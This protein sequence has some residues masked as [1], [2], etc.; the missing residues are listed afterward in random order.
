VPDLWTYYE[1]RADEYEAGT[2]EGLDEHA[3]EIH[4]EGQDIARVLTE[5]PEATFIDVGVGTG[6]FTRYLRGRGVALDQSMA[7]LRRLNEDLGVLPSIRADATRLPM[8]DNAVQRI[9][10]AHLYGHLDGHDREAFLN[11]ARRVGQQLVIVDSAR[12]PGV[13][14]EAWEERCLRDGSRYSIFKRFFTGEALAEE[15][16]GDVLYDGKYFVV[17]ASEAV[18]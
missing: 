5:L 13:P 10:A 3:E 16:R 6:L 15:V 1:R 17:T 7:M 11:E 9:F 2:L 12:R 14:A 4:A 18:T 8:C